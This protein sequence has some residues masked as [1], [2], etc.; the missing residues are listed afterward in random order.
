MEEIQDRFIPLVTEECLQVVAEGGGNTKYFIS[1]IDKM[2]QEQPHLFNK[3]I[4]SAMSITLE[5]VEDEESDEFK[6]IFTNML[7]IAVQT[8]LSIDKQIGIE[9][10][11]KT[12]G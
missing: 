11:E 2:I 10:L 9:Y 1:R 3:V 5:V 7:A 6:F 12:I 4:Q 8:Y